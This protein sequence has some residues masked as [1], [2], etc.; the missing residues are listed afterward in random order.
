M[1]NNPYQ[2]TDLPTGALAQTYER[3]ISQSSLALTSGRLCLSAIY[4]RAGLTVTSITYAGSSTAMSGGT[5]G[6]AALYTPSRTLMAQSPDDTGITWTVNTNKTFTLSSPQ[7]TTI[8]GWHYVGIMHTVTT[9]MPTLASI[10]IIQN[11][12]TVAPNMG[13]FSDS[14][15]TT[16]APSTAAAPSASFTVPYAYVS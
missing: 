13:G 10:I 14:G 6:W 11:V 5:H 3:R 7:T 2:I 1:F 12:T 15:L 4:L 8:E 16:T 9:T